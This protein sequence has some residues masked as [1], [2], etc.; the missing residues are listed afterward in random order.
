MARTAGALNK[1]TR[2]ALHAAQTGE[3]GAG[4]ESPVAFLL[5]TMRDS[6]KPDQLR[7]E[8]AKAVAPYLAPKLSAVELT[9]RSSDENFTETELLEQLKELLNSHPDL[10]KTIDNP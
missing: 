6:K 2:A 7:I 10:L 3:L 1:R 9:E 5:R 8:A 4:G